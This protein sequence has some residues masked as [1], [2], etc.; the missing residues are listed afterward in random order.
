MFVLERG[1]QCIELHM[2]ECRRSACVVSSSGTGVK[3]AWVRG[4]GKRACES[5]LK[6]LK[7]MLVFESLLLLSCV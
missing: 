3:V 4:G 2:P 1:L 5:R 7:M 6:R